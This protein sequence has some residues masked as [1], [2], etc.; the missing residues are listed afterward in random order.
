MAVN[1]NATEAR[2]YAIPRRYQVCDCSGIGRVWKD[3]I[4]ERRR[5]A[6]IEEPIECPF[7]VAAEAEW[8]R[9]RNPLVIVGEVFVHVH[10]Y[11]VA[12]RKLLFIY[13]PCENRKMIHG[14]NRHDHGRA[15]TRTLGLL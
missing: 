7:H 12:T 1:T 13:Q 3:T 8:M 4:L 9:G 2:I 15:T 6:R 11:R 10:E 5:K 14:T